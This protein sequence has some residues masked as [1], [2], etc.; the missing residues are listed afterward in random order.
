MKEDELNESL[1]QFKQACMADFKQSLMGGAELI[2][3][4]KGIEYQHKVKKEMRNL[5]YQ[6]KERNRQ[7]FRK[8]VNDLIQAA[9]DTEVKPKIDNSQSSKYS[10]SDLKRD[11]ESIRDRFLPDYPTE[12]VLAKV[13]DLSWQMTDLV[14]LSFKQTAGNAERLANEKVQQ[15]QDDMKELK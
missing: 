1:K 5:A 3:S 9:I 15:V 13:N 8:T 12:L 7:V 4:A 2:N 6:I 11:M 10:L 14:V